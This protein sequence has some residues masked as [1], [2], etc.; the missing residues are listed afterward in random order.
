MMSYP[1]PIPCHT[2]L[3]P[4]KLFR[5]RLHLMR[6][7]PLSVGHSV[8]SRAAVLLAHAAG[9]G[10]PI[11][12]AVAAEAGVAHQINILDVSAVLQVRDETAEGRRRYGII[13]L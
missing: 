6:C 12:E 10:E 4:G 7:L 11:A 1:L 3:H 5:R 2:R 13:N 8:H 9:F